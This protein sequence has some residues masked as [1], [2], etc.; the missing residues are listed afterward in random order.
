MRLHQRVLR[1]AEMFRDERYVRVSTTDMEGQ[2]GA[3]LLAGLP[4]FPCKSYQAALLGQLGQKLTAIRIEADQSK[5]LG[6]LTITVL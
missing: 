4:V 5:F 6:S 2:A 1:P 3:C